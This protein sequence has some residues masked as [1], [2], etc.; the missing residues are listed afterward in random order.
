MDLFYSR[1]SGNSSRSVFALAEA[2]VPWNPRPVDW[3]GGETHGTAYLAINPMG[4]VPA[5]ADGELRLW[6]SN[7][8]NWYLAEKHPECGLL[9][10]SM[11]GRAAVHRWLFFQAGHVGPACFPIVRTLPS[12]QAFW[13]ATTD[14][15]AVE[16]GR[17]ELGRYLPVLE[18]ALVGRDWL[19]GAFS[20]ADITYA[21]HFMLLGRTGFDFSP[22]PALQAWLDR[23]LARPA[24]QQTMKLIYD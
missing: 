8:I 5:L 18:S 16:A 6:E 10:G 15:Q 9:P 4:K 12:V 11:T 20:L 14:P 17:K 2:G 21:P 1:N 23:L 19:E 7:A 3:R 13:N 22:Y 24:W